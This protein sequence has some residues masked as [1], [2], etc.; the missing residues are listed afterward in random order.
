MT[1]LVRRS[2]EATPLL[3]FVPLDSIDVLE[4]PSS[5]WG[6]AEAGR[7]LTTLVPGLAAMSVETAAGKLDELS[8]PVDLTLP[9]STEVTAL[10]AAARPD[11]NLVLSTAGFLPVASV[12]A[13]MEPPPAPPP[14][15][16]PAPPAPGGGRVI[17]R[18]RNRV[19]DVGDAVVQLAGRIPIV[20]RRRGGVAA[21]GGGVAA[22]V[23]AGVAVLARNSLTADQSSLALSVL[24]ENPTL[25]SVSG[26]RAT[27]DVAAFE[28]ASRT[29]RDATTIDTAD[30]DAVVAGTLVTPRPVAA[31]FAIPAADRT[32]LGDELSAVVAGLSDRFVRP[33]DAAARPGRPLVGGV[34]ALKA[35]VLT[36]LDPTVTLTR[37]VNHRIAGLAAGLEQHFDEI[38]AAPDLSEPTYGALAKISHDWLLPGIDQLPT[39]TTTLVANNRQFIDAFLVGMNHELARELLWREYPTDQRGTYARQF[40]TRRRTANRADQF[41]LRHELHAAPTLDLAGLSG[42]GGDPLVLVVKGDL[43]R[44]Y[45]GMIVS[46]ATTTPA[47]GGARHLNPATVMD[48]DFV[49]LLEPDVMLVGFEGL[50]EPMVRAVEDDPDKAYWVFFA[51]HFA[52]PRFGFDELVEDNVELGPDDH[53]DWTG[54]NRSWNDAAWQ[55]ATL[56]AR[57]FLTAASFDAALPKGRDVANPVMHAWG[58]DAAGQAWISLQFPFR[59]GIAAKTLLPPKV[60]P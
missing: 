55:F 25:V 17:G 49:G 12:T 23:G 36:A 13:V 47:A 1:T 60:A 24:E 8:R 11:P 53:R 27:V 30:F 39:D 40:W 15:P 38:M 18:V 16:P 7:I 46:V 3:Q 2:A 6:Q 5:L 50:T 31:D 35:T 34:D 42:T 59:R 48:P 14:P 44:R 51:E 22:G 56:D 28:R 45:P 32:V 26:D 19:R 41:D 9:P 10:I 43:V 58:T 4:A 21:G 37:A 54:A 52:E 57:G 29:G 33:A 20:A